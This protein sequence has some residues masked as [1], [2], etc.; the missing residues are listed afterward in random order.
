MS[1]KIGDVKGG[2]ADRAAV[3]KLE[4]SGPQRLYLPVVWGWRKRLQENRTTEMYRS[5]AL[6][7][8]S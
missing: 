5:I 3:L 2:R 1:W 6:V 8:V 4:G 7:H